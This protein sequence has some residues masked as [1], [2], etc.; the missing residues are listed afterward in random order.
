MYRMALVANAAYALGRAD[1]YGRIIAKFGR[2]IEASG[3]DNLKADHSLVYSYGASLQVETVSLWALAVMKSPACDRLLVKTCIDFLL[4]NRR[5]GQFGSTQATALALTAL[6]RYAELMRATSHDGAIQVLVNNN[7]VQC[8]D[9]SKDAMETLTV[10]GFDGKLLAGTKPVLR[11]AFK[12]TPESLPYSLN[13]SWRTKL[14]PSA[15]D[16]HIQIGTAL[17]AS[18]VD[19]NG[20]VRLSI[21]LRNVTHNGLPMTMAVVG[22]P[23]GLSPQPW[24]LKE[25]QEKGVFDFY[26]LQNGR[27][28]LY[29]REMAPDGVAV[30]NLDL[31][32]EVA[33][34]YTG[35]ASCA[36]LYY[37]DELKHWAAGNRITITPGI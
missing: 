5:Y 11:V 9:Y 32:A 6:T 28:M 33:G 35:A 13:L 21:T 2:Q 3:I 30:V 26:E 4:R 27:V 17:A 10:N 23:G 16:S 34:T 19:V 14:P 20:T 18:R 37:Y 7:V 31:K 36:Y 12:D 8:Q 22:I 15:K 25:L 24:Q 29:F 1:D